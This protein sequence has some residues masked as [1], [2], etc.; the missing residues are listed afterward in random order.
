MIRGNGRITVS[1]ATSF[2]AAKCELEI[3][4]WKD[5]HMKGFAFIINLIRLLENHVIFVFL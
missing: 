5:D 2:I 4:S 3:I 1:N